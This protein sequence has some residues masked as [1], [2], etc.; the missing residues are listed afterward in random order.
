MKKQL[1]RR[2][3]ECGQCGSLLEGTL[4]SEDV[5]SVTC[6]ECVAAR[7]KQFDKPSKKKQ[8]PTKGYP[9]GWRFKKVFV[10]ENGTVYYRGVEQPKLKGTLEP[11]PIAIKIKK[12]KAQKAQERSELINQYVKLKK[13]LKEAT[14]K[15]EIKKLET[16]IKKL[17]KQLQ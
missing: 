12:S 3:L 5:I 17:E 16:Q 6:W 9:K 13:Q 8:Q 7:V 10:H 15:T 11:T 4:R 2:I 14:K 1:D